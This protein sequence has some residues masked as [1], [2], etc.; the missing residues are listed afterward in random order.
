M[1]KKMTNRKFPRLIAAFGFLVFILALSAYQHPAFGQTCTDDQIV[2]NVN[3]QL[4]A[5]KGLAT[6][7]SHINVVSVNGAVKL[8]G[9]TN[10]K[11]DYDR[12]VSIVSGT[13]C[14]KLINVNLFEPVPPPSNSTLRSAGGSCA[15]G[16]KPC[17]DVCIPE[18]DSCN[19]GPKT[20]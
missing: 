8:E 16:T 7:M 19:I 6:Q 5:D 10:A 12:V 18:G 20:P 3:K 14:V 11:S 2:A 9:W 15:T 1:E 4:A 17:G 13:A